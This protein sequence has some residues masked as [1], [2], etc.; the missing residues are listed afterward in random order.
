MTG[1]ALGVVATC[2]L[3][4]ASLPATASAADVPFMRGITVGEWGPTA[5][6]PKKTRAL[7][8]TLARRQHV[9]TVT[10]FVAWTQAARESVVVTPGEKTVPTARLRTAIRSAR[11]AGLRVVLRP[12]LEP[13]PTNVWR[14]AIQPTSVPQWFASYRRFILRYADLARRERVSGFIVGTE[15][16][17][18]S[19]ETAHW[20]AL[21]AAVR[22]RFKGFVTYQANW[23]ETSRVKF[24]DALDAVSLSAY[25][26]LARGPGA[27][28]TQLLSGWRGWM[29]HVEAL[30]SASGKPVMF[31]EIGYRTVDSAAV[32]PWDIEPATFSLTAQLRA[33]EAA[34]RF[35]YRVPWFSGFHW[36]YVAA[37]RAII[38]G[39]RGAD[40]RPTTQALQLIARFYRRSRGAPR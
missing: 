13:T 24:W 11:A 3:A 35:W 8:R 22:R 30:H 5:Y 18:L 15:M 19:D 36:W 23:D 34:L 27:S 14:G 31:G 2:A 16:A 26:P 1:R 12:Y 17:S 21:V 4:L 29:D 28:V 39:R 40:H 20:R 10:F 7:L 38:D 9:D 32:K 25:Y 33:Y 37:Q 6:P